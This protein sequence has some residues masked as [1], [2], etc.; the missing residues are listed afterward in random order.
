[1]TGLMDLVTVI[2]NQ[3]QVASRSWTAGEPLWNI[4]CMAVLG[5]LAQFSYM[6]GTKAGCQESSKR[7]KR[8]QRDAP[9]DPPIVIAASVSSGG[10]DANLSK[11]ESTYS[12]I[13]LKCNNSTSTGSSSTG[14][15]DSILG[16]VIVPTFIKTRN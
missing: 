2:T 7:Q 9:C 8:A 13:R 14:S 16:V 15:S 11:S 12:E 4:I 6:A 5:I 1:M 3:R 10:A